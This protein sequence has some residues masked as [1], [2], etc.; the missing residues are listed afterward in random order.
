MCDFCTIE[1]FARRNNISSRTVKNNFH[2]IKGAYIEDNTYYIPEGSRYPFFPKHMNLTT[3][4]DKKYAVLRALFEYRYVDHEIVKV[5]KPSFKVI[6]DELL[7][8]GFIK[9][10]G[11]KNPYGLNMYD[12]TDKAYQ[13]I[14]ILKS[15][16]NIIK[17]LFNINALNVAVLAGEAVGAGLATYN[18]IRNN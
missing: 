5:D 16:R 4:I 6:V 7:E 11:S 3:K 13:E 9:L 8:D 2:L 12:I 15:K 17:R 10:N 1:Q 14:Y 18:E